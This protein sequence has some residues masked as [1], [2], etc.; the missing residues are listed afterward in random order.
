MFSI[1]SYL[2]PPLWKH[3]TCMTPNDP[4]HSLCESVLL[5]ALGLHL[6]SLYMTCKAMTVFQSYFSTSSTYLEQ[7]SGTLYVKLS[8][9]TLFGNIINSKHVIINDSFLIYLIGKCLIYDYCFAND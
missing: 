3:A 8:A 6:L 9:L 1:G 2:S 5:V 7:T 4:L